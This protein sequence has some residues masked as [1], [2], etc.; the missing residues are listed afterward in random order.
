VSEPWNGLPQ[1]PEQRCPHIVDVDG[2]AWVCMWEPKDKAWDFGC[3]G[4]FMPADAFAAHC[5]AEGYRYLG[6]CL[7]PAEVAA[8][9]QAEREA[10]AEVCDMREVGW[11]GVCGFREQE[12]ADCAAGIRARGDTSALDA[13]LAAA[14]AR[15]MERALKAL[16]RLQPRGHQGDD[17]AYNR[18]INT[19]FMH[20]RSDAE[21]AIRAQIAAKEDG[22]A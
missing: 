5:A 15:G 6:P 8:A 12:A 7:T 2:D 18:G 4:T 13:A 17:G 9:V 3:S 22:D 1:N 10:C 20:A 16:F 11:G 21:A 19:G 14:E